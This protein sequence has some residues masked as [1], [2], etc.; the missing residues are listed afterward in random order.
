[1]SW[2]KNLKD[3][4]SLNN[5]EFIVADFFAFPATILADELKIPNII[6]FPGPLEVMKYF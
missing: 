4:F 3:V 5:F 1:M 2:K 6:N